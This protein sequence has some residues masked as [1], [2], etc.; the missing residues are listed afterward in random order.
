GGGRADDGPEGD[1]DHD[2]R[3]QRPES[4][5]DRTEL[6]PLR[7]QRVGEGGCVKG[8]PVVRA[9]GSD[10]GA[11]HRVT[12]AAWYSTLSRVS[13]MKASSSEALTGVSSN[14]TMPWAA[15]SLPTSALS[16]PVI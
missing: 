6:G 7:A 1:A 16:I 9:G 5:P 12:P 2:G 8:C 10:R 3:G 15:A 11:G 14:R 4:R 13:S